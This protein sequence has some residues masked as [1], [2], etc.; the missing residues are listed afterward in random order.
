MATARSRNRTNPPPRP[1]RDHFNANYDHCDMVY[2]PLALSVPNPRIRKT[3][4]R[5]IAT[6]RRLADFGCGHGVGLWSMKSLAP[7]GAAFTGIDYSDV[8]IAKARIYVGAPSVDLKVGD[9][10]LPKPRFLPAQLDLLYSN[11]VI[12]HLPDPDAFLKSCHRALKSG[13]KFYLGTVY[14]KTW[15]WYF[16]RNQAGQTVLEPTHLREY[17]E[18]R[19]LLGP[20]ERHGFQVV[21]WKLS[22]VFYPVLD[23]LLKVLSRFWKGPGAFRFLNAAFVMNLR[24]FFVVP[25]PG[26][27]LFQVLAEKQTAR[28]IDKSG[29]R[30]RP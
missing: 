6:S 18:V 13:G 11:Q 12:E 2:V 9:F 29:T 28:A 21:D 7:T 23:P 4:T 25:V 30:K 14:K 26:Y 24:R 19:D 1:D 3:L 15:A 20:V 5:W 8:A 27:Y 16:Y 17:T 22:P 10:C